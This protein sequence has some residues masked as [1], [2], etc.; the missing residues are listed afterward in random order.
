MQCTFKAT[1]GC[2][3]VKTG[4]MEYIKDYLLFTSGWR[5]ALIIFCGIITG[6]YLCCCCFCCFFCCWGTY[7]YGKC[8]P[9]QPEDTVDCHNLHD[10]PV[11]GAEGPV[12]TSKPRASEKLEASD[13]GSGVPAVTL[14]T[15]S[16]S[17]SQCHSQLTIMLQK[18]HHWI[19]MIKLYTHQEWQRKFPP[20]I[21]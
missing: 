9:P 13:H 2:V 5:K 21:L 10:N 6:H 8:K 16:A 15:S 19:Y 4:A 1:F 20:P 17:G 11:S 7:W 3:C 14:K 12:V 18:T